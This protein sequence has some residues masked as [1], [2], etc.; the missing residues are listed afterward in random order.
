M[1]NNSQFMNK[2]IQKFLNDHL[3]AKDFELAP[4]KK[5]G[6]DRRFFRVSLPDKTSYIFM[7]YGNEV[8]E[9]AYWA[10]INNFLAGLDIRVPKIIAQDVSQH[11]LL[12]EDLGDV[13]L[14][15]QRELPWDKR[16]DYY[17]RTLTQI[18]RVHAYP[19]AR[20]PADLKLSESYGP[21]LYKWEH[22]Y[23]LGNLVGEVCKIKLPSSLLKELKKELESLGARLQ[24]ID[25][26]LIH[27]DFQSQNI[28]IKNGK[29]V[30]IDFQGM[31]Q[32]CLFYD[33]GSLICD[34]YVTFTAE[35]RNEL[36]S[37]YYKL[38]KPAVSLDEFLNN[39]WEASAQRLMQAL[40]AYGF[41]GLKK[42][43]PIFLKHINNGL[44][45]LIIAV[46]QTPK[47]VRLKDLAIQCQ[48]A[49]VGKKH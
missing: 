33:L 26:C 48:T 35:E 43:K 20:I 44:T 12:I 11:F 45:N 13:D 8:E 21:E 5:G 25:P 31:R 16:R 30:L 15:S 37:F 17:F 10:G 6:S 18:S 41:L 4:I 32:G 1:K 46:N 3:G 42:N 9:N 22:D 47:L 36:I 38:M 28:M 24:K 34:P 19:L 40:G 7:H 29:P 27:R 39:F 2:E 14:W 23:F 49:L